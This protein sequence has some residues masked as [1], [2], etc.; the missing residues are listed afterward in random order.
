MLIFLARS[1]WE[2]ERLFELTDI[3]I[4]YL[5]DPTS[6]IAAVDVENFLRAVE[7]E[8]L[9]AD[10][11]LFTK[12]GHASSELR[13]WGVLD[14]VLR[15]MLKPQDIYM[16]PQ[17]FISYFVSPAPPTVNFEAMPEAVSFDLPISSAEYPL[18]VNYLSA[19][20]EGLPRFW[21]KELSQVRWRHTNVK[22]AWSEAQNP[23]LVEPEIRPKPELLESL[24]KGVEI[25]HAQVESRTLE[26]V[27]LENEVRELKQQLLIAQQSRLPTTNVQARAAHEECNITL[28]RR[29]LNEL[30]E[31]IFRLN[32]YLTRCQQALTFVKGAFRREPQVQ[33]VL[34][35]INWETMRGQYPW[36]HLQ[37]I[38]GF[39]ALEKML[40]PEVAKAAPL[41]PTISLS[42]RVDAMGTRLRQDMKVSL[43][44]NVV[45][46]AQVQLPL[47]KIEAALWQIL[48]LASR[49]VRENGEIL[50]RNRLFDDHMDIY[51]HVSPLK[52]EDKSDSNAELPLLQ[53]LRSDFKPEIEE[54]REILAQMKGSLEVDDSLPGQR[55]Y[56][57]MFGTIEERK[58]A[59]HELSN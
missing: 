47:S 14:S 28:F 31:N 1:G 9:G 46:F 38:E 4:E 27:R 21:G 34:R 26:I 45:D 35:K 5:R 42:Q 36:L 51:V 56:K 55:I 7:K 43:R 52:P 19:A 22:I 18:T 15:M 44:N 23:L 32:D 37:V 54:V 33:T 13:G 25:A 2:R 12:T 17:R 50:L 20:L 30:R 11:L 29:H 39:D 53:S 6:W 58:G 40:D 10:A 3:P 16:Q 48:Q 59:E 41:D 57:C 49:E 24:L 8:Y